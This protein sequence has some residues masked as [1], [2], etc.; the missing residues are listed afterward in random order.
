[1]ENGQF[2][3]TNDMLAS[4]GQR[5]ANYF[6]DLLVQYGLTFGFGFV[7]AAFAMFAGYEGMLDW[8]ANIDKI[9]EYLLGVVML[10]L[11]YSF[12]EILFARSIAKYITKTVVVMADG[13]KPSAGTIV[14]RTFCRII[15]FNH[16]SFLG[17][18]GRG[19]HDSI[20]DTYVVKK[21][22]FDQKKDLFYSFDEI[23]KQEE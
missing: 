2:K 21:D 16:F 5:L 8:L 17:N 13:S 18:S 15:P 20:S 7:L 9:T 3:V 12:F 1:M 23:G 4:Q 10:I 6:I 22:V 11:Y 14:K 19:W